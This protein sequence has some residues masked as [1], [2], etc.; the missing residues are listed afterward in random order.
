MN[1]QQKNSNIGISGIWFIVLFQ[2]ALF[3]PKVFNK[4]TWSWLWVLAPIWLPI[5]LLLSIFLI[6]LLTYI[7]EKMQKKAQVSTSKKI[8]IID[9]DI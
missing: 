6:L 5:A 3:V 2:I 8:K 9:K 1:I 4:I 7:V